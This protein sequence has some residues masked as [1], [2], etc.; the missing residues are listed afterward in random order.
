M[1]APAYCMRREL[2]ARACQARSPRGAVQ[3][4][5][6][7][8]SQPAGRAGRPAV[9]C[10]DELNVEQGAASRP[11]TGEGSPASASNVGQ[12][13]LPAIPPSMDHPPPVTRLLSESVNHRPAKSASVG[14]C[15]ACQRSARPSFESNPVRLPSLQ[16]EK[17]TFDASHRRC[18]PLRHAAQCARAAQCHPTWRSG[19]CRA[20]SGRPRRQSRVAARG[21]RAHRA[22]ASS[23]AGCRGASC[24]RTT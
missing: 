14:T 20:A 4:H 6:G 16:S 5:P 23:G 9:P 12:Q 2:S 3:C 15:A 8:P 21:L 1:R 22:R 11:L 13:D 10:V 7:D 17:I 24:G 19:R 18:M